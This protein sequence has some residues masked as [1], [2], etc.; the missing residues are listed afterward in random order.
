MKHKKPFIYKNILLIYKICD[1][2][3][4]MNN[5]SYNILNY[6]AQK[7]CLYNLIKYNNYINKN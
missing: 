3:H 4:N 7:K 5:Y 1:E 6:K 2:N